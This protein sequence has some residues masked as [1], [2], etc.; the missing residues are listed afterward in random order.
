[1]SEKNYINYKSNK[2][3]QNQAIWTL[4]PRLLDIK[5]PKEREKE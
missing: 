4:D 1:M 3:T 5:W 2:K